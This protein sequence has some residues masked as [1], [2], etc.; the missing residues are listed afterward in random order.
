MA[1]YHV[2]ITDNVDRDAIELLEQTDGVTVTAPGKMA[3]EAV[4]SVIVG[5]D[6]LLVR[7]G[8]HVDAELLMAAPRL[9][10]IVRAGVGVDNVDLTEATQRGIVVMNTPDGNTV[11]TAE[12]TIAL[13]L[14]L[15]RHIPAAQRSMQEGRWDRQSFK[16]FE[17]HGK[18]LGIIGFG[19]VGR[20]VAERARAFGMHV[21]AHDPY[22]NDDILDAADRI[23]I[24]LVS[25]DELY[26][27]SEVISL[28]PTLNDDTRGMINAQS[29]A[30]MKPGITIVNTARGALIVEADLAAAIASGHV[31]GAAVDVYAQEP[32]SPTHPL[33]GLPEVIHTPHL[34]ASTH[35]AQQAVALQAAQQIIDA[36]LKGKYQNVVN[37]DALRKLAG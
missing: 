21:I 23:D 18:T 36:L 32:P 30:R 17:L 28:H 10:V 4:L 22:L 35:E 31:A 25:L 3:R 6:A 19:R 29:I 12:F 16:G 15:A 14:A 24:R 13:M 8:T 1:N 11:A 26:T 27:L 9:R 7:S 37:P 2:L 34:A 5:A 33:T 20:A